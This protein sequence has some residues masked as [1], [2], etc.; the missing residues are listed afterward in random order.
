MD[1]ATVIVLHGL[2]RTHRS[3]RGLERA[4]AGAGFRTWSATYPSRRMSVVDLARILAERIEKEAPAKRYHAVTHSLGGILVRY[5][6]E[7][8]PWSR[9]VMLAPPNRGTRIGSALRDLPLYRWLY[10]PAG[11]D[12]TRPERWPPPPSPF[13]VIAGTRSFSIA[14]PTSWITSGASLFPPGTPNDGTISVEETKLEGM[15][16][17]AE[18][19]ATHT[20]IMNHARARMLALE[21]LVH[22]AF[23]AREGTAS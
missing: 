8:L 15:S 5:M 4:I 20:F 6:K 2:A 17:F 1:D 23:N 3:V 14:N 12:L 16:A 11:Q 18:V 7:S 10:G 22:G 9:V 21:F 13:A 19:D